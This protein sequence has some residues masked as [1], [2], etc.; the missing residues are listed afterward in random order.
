M[1]RHRSV[2][3]MLMLL[4]GSLSPPTA[5]GQDTRAQSLPETAR[6]F[7]L[8]QNSPNPVSDETW[9]PF[10]LEDQLFTTADTIYVTIRIYNSLRQVV[11]IPESINYP[12][13]GRHRV[14]NI[15]YTTPG[16]KLAYW[17]GKDPGG[18]RVPT[19]VYYGQLEVRGF[20]EP[21]ARK[22]IV[23]N[24]TRRRRIIPWFGRQ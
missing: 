16:R 13:R 8:E 3:L 12:S 2:L 10:T 21:A 5:R 14:F 9:I 1:Q 6:G 15:P 4:A 7:S 11:G 24:P 20:P 22:I 18:R 17:D 19:G 23:L